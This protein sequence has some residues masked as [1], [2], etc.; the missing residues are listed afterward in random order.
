[1]VRLVFELW[2]VKS[3]CFI[4]MTGLTRM[5]VPVKALYGH[6]N[7]FEKYSY[8]LQPTSTDSEIEETERHNIW[9]VNY[10]QRQLHNT[11]RT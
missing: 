10:Q 7:M 2:V 9:L 1:M 8:I 5:L 6:M 4:A 11:K 3:N